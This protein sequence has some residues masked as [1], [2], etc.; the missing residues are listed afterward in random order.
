MSIN[1][2][3]DLPGNAY[4]AATGANSASSSNVFATINDLTAATASTDK[5]IFD[6]KYNQIGGLVK[7]QAVYINGSDGTNITVGKAD[8][9]TEATSSKT[10]GL[11]VV[12]GANN[13]QGQVIA[14][15]LL[16]NIDTSAANAAGDPVWLGANG[17]LIYGLVNKPYAP[18]HLVFIGIVTKKNASTG[19]IFVKIQ[20]GFELDE[21]HDVDL[22]SNPPTD[23]QVLTY[24]N[25]SGLW[26][27][28]DLPA[29]IGASINVNLEPVIENTITDPSTLSPNFGD[30]YLVPVGAIGVWAGQDNNIATWDGEQWL[31]YTPAALDITTVLTGTNAGNVYQFD[32]VSWVLITSTSPTATPFYLAG[33]GVDAGG[34]KTSTIA[35]I[36]SVVLGS[37]SGSI[38]SSPL[39]VRGNASIENTNTRWGMGSG[40]ATGLNNWYRIADFNVDY[41][42]SKNYQILVNIGGKS[43]NTFASVVLHI[44][45]SKTSPS[46]STG[47]AICRVVNVSGPGYLSVSGDGDY[48]LNE[49]NFEFRRYTN[50]GLGSVVFRLY[51]KPTI[52]DSFMSTTVLN[53]N[54]GGTSG[55]IGINWINTLLGAAIEAPGVGGAVTNYATFSYSG[56]R[57]NI[58][59]IVDPT[60]TDDY[61]SQYTVGSLWYNTVTQKVFQCLDSASGAAVWKQ[62]TPYDGALEN[63]IMSSTQWSRTLA[64]PVNLPDGTIANG[65]TFFSDATDRVTGGCTSYNEFFIAFTRKLT[66]TGTSGTANINIDGTNYL[67]TFATSLTQTATN[68]V[69]THAATIFANHGVRVAANG[70][71][72]R[73]GYSAAA[74]LNAITITNVTTN[75]SGTFD[76]AI[77]DHI[78]IPYVGTPYENLRLQHN[79]RV[80]FG[81]VVGSTQT[82]ALSLRRW[83]NDS[84][85]GSE[86]PIFRNAD[87]SGHQ[88]NFIS[89][90]AGASDPFVTGGF[91]FALRNNS[92][93]S[94]MDIEGTVGILIQN[95]FQKPVNF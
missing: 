26:I 88:E 48:R 66:L 35:R 34:N 28:D 7:G 4:D 58:S 52:P 92:G 20:N 87:V 42:T 19:E 32:G 54:G 29:T 22:I 86:I 50:V 39:T 74:L 59:A 65:F 24:D 89:Y 46:V 91:Y 62:I 84:V 81:L 18:N 44:N 70:A 75:L 49:S 78:V 10:L 25:G 76:T 47:R 33:S 55:N 53:N 11:V 71:V 43:A 21:I 2:N 63:I 60:V 51:Y 8:Y 31:F 79:F 68:F 16:D 3:R 30:A 69:T 77:G 94:I 61:T 38:G 5:I 36:G 85:I 90:T 93:T 37:N 83:I 6:A 82:L 73:F 9:T 80:N 56:Q 12:S 13:F 67:A 15:G 95:Y 64:A 14:E 57:T 45:I 27:N 72:L 17:N 40:S 41:G 23:G 1:I